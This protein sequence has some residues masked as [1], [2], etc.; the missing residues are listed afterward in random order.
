MNTLDFLREGWEVQ[1]KMYL[2]QGLHDLVAEA[3]A[4][5]R[6]QE[7][8]M[9]APSTFKHEWEDVQRRLR[10]AS[11]RKLDED[12][13]IAADPVLQ[14]V[15][16]AKLRKE[17]RLADIGARLRTPRGMVYVGFLLIAQARLKDWHLASVM[18]MRPDIADALGSEIEEGMESPLAEKRLRQLAGATMRV[19]EVYYKP[20]LQMIWK[21][22]VGMAGYT[23]RMPRMCGDLIRSCKDLWLTLTEMILPTNFLDEEAVEVRNGIAHPARTRFDVAMQELV[24]EKDDG[25]DSR[26]TETELRRRLHGIL[27]RCTLMDF[28]FQW[29][30]G[31]LPGDVLGAKEAR[32]PEAQGAVDAALTQAAADTNPPT[33]NA[34]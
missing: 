4:I 1:R 7:K 31:S 12:G 9:H 6:D 18:P 5:S 15:E 8:L 30:A 16:F 17:A 29:V 28:A 3:D 10:E 33:S 21:L 34:K 11:D 14:W 19:V 2:A 13:G 22:T 20:L 25:T 23:K 32:T 24:F 26:F 27:Y